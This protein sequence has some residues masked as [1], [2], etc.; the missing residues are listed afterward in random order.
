VSPAEPLPPAA[1]ALDRKFGGIG[2]D[3][4]IDLSLVG[5]NVRTAVNG[6]YR[7]IRAIALRKGSSEIRIRPR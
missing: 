3:P 1:N 4:D 2:I 6:R 7:S 5:G